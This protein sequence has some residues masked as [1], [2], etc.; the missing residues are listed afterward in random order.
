MFCSSLSVP[1]V[2]IQRLRKSNYLKDYSKFFTPTVGRE[3]G[4]RQQR[5]ELER[6]IPIRIELDE[7]LQELTG[8]K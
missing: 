5:L 3:R 8:Q 7:R 6:S 1:S 2:R 4:D